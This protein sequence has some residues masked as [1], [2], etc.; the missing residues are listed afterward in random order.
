MSKLSTQDDRSGWHLIVLAKNQTGYKN[1]IKIVSLSWTEGFYG[2]PRI[3]K[4]LLEKYHEGLIVCSACIGGEIP[5]LILN[6]QSIRRKNPFSGSK[7][8]SATIIIWRFNVTRRMTR[9]PLKM[10]IPIK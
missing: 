7:T 10:Y 4:E 9:Q 1:L 3:D 6:G 5:Q 2:R 8:Y